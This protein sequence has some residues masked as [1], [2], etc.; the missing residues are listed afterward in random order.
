MALT[1][2]IQGASC[3]QPTALVREP[4]AC[5]IGVPFERPACPGHPAQATHFH[6]RGIR[7]RDPGTSWTPRSVCKQPRHAKRFFAVTTSRHQE[8]VSVN[9]PLAF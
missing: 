7:H 4:G 1:K 3:V 2:D 8:D 6:G 9:A 5:S